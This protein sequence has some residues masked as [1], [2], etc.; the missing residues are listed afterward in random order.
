[1]KK[2]SAITLVSLVV[3]I[4]ILILLAGISINTLVGN[5]GII[6]KTKEAKE[7]ILLAQKE[8]A[9]Q[10]NQ[11]Y[12]QLET[13]ENGEIDTDKEAIQNLLHFK[14][15]IA[16]AITNAGVSTQETDGAE[17]MASHIGK[18][19][20]ER[21]K[22]ATA[23]ADNLSVGT[24]AWVKGM[25]ITGTGKDVTNAYQQGYAAANSFNIA[26]FN[27]IGIYNFHQNEQ[28]HTA[29]ISN[30]TDYQKIY[31]IVMFKY[32]TGGGYAFQVTVSGGNREIL[33]Q[34]TAIEQGWIEPT[35]TVTIKTYYNQQA[36]HA[37]SY[38]IVMGVKK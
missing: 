9:K 23:I 16:S 29:T 1:M 26:S 12:S 2:E 25:Q 38:I 31:Y 14:K 36:V 35:Q 11:L 21:T 22:N 37:D 32:T 13:I 10:L 27:L 24:T 30:A 8:E 34:N 28:W 20:P 18:I 17:V 4:I 5:N 7:N 33:Y 3:T 19:L 15:V 6:T